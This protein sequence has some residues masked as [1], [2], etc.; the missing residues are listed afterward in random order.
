MSVTSGMI[1]GDRIGDALQQHRFAGAGRGDDQAALAFAD[2]RDR[3]ITRPEKLSRTVSSFRRAVGIQR[4][5]VVEEDLVARF[6]GRLEVDRVHLDQREVALAFLGRANLAGDRVAGAQIEAADLRGR[7]VNVVG[8]GQVVVLGGAQEAEAVR[9]A[10]EHAFGEDQAALF[11]LRLQDLEDQFLLAKAGGV[12]HAH[13][14]GDLVEVDGCS[15]LSARPDRAWR[16]VFRLG[17]R[18]VAPVAM[19]AA[20]LHWFGAVA[21]RLRPLL[22]RGRSAVQ[23]RGVILFAGLVAGR[24]GGFTGRPIFAGRPF[25]RAL[26][27]LVLFCGRCGG[28]YR[29]WSVFVITCQISLTPRPVEAENGSG[30][31][32]SL[33][34]PAKPCHCSD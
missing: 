19:V 2:G 34:I 30:S 1:G 12:L 29:V 16:A 22:G 26:G 13:V 32:C 9:Q 21:C 11:R 3:S 7:D 25:G 14:L 20:A 5:Q 6:L 17:G 8:A 33:R 18:F 24:P 31:T 28:T 15:C 27:R 4:R 10:F 23:R